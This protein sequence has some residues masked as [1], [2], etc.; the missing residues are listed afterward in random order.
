M[1]PRTTLLITIFAVIALVGIVMIT[2][3]RLHSPA[4][5]SR[6]AAPSS[7]SRDGGH[8]ALPPGIGATKAGER[9]AAAAQRNAPPDPT[10][11]KFNLDEIRADGLRGPSDGL[12]SVSYEFRVPADEA[13]YREVKRI[14]PSVRISS[15]NAEKGAFCLGSTSQPRWREILMELSS[16]PYVS[17]IRECFFE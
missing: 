1:T 12:V 11:I 6:E 2:R 7:S 5:G 15:V 17:E 13:I 10:K 9:P 8:G 4:A 3:Q 14:D 16:L